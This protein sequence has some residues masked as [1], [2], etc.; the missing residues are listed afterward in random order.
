MKLTIAIPTYNR[1]KRLEKALFDLSSEINSASNKALIAVYVSNNGSKDNTSEVI[2]RFS[3]RF[4]ENGI[5]FSSREAAINQGFD[6]NVLACYAGSQSEYVWFLSDDDNIITGAIDAIIQDINQY[7]PTVVYYNHDQ[8]PYDKTQPYIQKIEYFD[9]VN[10]DNINALRKIVFWPKL[11]SLVIKR[12][13]AGLNVPNKNCGFSHVTLALQC[14]LNGGMVLHSPVFTAHPDDDY[15]ENIDFPPYI[16]NNLDIGIRWVLEDNNK[17]HLYND[18]AIGLTD[19]LISTLNTLGAYY[20]GRHVLTLPLKTE[21]WETVFREIK[22]KWLKRIVDWKSIKELVKFPVS[23]A[24]GFVF[25][26]ITRKRITKIRQLLSD[27]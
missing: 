1:A 5:P 2:E 19:P 17:M 23:V 15:T 18:L 6:A 10:K 12:C 14:G 8:K 27:N 26:M 3:K 22:G 20:R 21:L 4:N 13:K 24:Y 25:T 9:K 7:N 11:T 16:A